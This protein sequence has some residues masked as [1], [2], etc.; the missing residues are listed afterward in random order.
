MTVPGVAVG[1]HDL[2]A[3][4]AGDLRQAQL[5]GHLRPDL[6]GVAVDGLPAAEHQVDGAEPSH[7]EGE[8]VAGGQR[9][10]AGERARR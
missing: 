10:G 1:R 5:L 9:V 6:G 4:D 7:G 3:A 2:D 8:G